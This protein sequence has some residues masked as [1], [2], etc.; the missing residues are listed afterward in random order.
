MYVKKDIQE[1][2]AKIV[3]GLI[4]IQWI[5]QVINVNCAIKIKLL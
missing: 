1:F 4:I 5:D 3:I 2:S